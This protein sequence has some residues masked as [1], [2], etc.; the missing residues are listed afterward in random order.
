MKFPENSA[1]KA[2]ERILFIADRPW[3]R[4]P[5]NGKQYLTRYKHKIND[6]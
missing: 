5:N 4:S 3:Q 2:H 6:L 1:A